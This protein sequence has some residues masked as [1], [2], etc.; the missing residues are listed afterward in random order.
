MFC[1]NCG[2]ENTGA[3]CSHCG[4]KLERFAVMAAEPAITV[5]PAQPAHQMQP[6]PSI[7]APIN[8][9]AAPMPPVR[10]AVPSR[11]PGNGMPIPPQPQQKK[12]HEVVHRIGGSAAFLTAV[13]AV[14]L[15][16]I[17]FFGQVLQ[18]S[19]NFEFDEFRLFMF[20]SWGP[21]L[22]FFFLFGVLI[23][24]GLWITFGTTVKHSG[25]QMTTAGLTMIKVVSVFLLIIFCLLSTT[26]IIV[27]AVAGV[28][29]GEL[30][31][32]LHK[33]FGGALVNMEEAG[34]LL[35]VFAFS[36]VVCGIVLGILYFAGIIKTLN[37]VRESVQTG[38]I[39]DRVSAYV[40][41][42]NFLAA[43]LMLY[44]AV[45]AIQAD[46]I[47]DAFQTVT[48][49]VGLITFG[50]CIF[51]YRDAMRRARVSDEPG[52]M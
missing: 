23:L 44:G 14:T 34:I 17:L 3:F 35:Y 29:L 43:T 5:P 13:I 27:L 24:V 40:A 26:M 19:D 45:R 36:L 18:F 25:G 42:I 49:C 22:G 8:P 52:P 48:Q 2:T 46:Q 9:S 15:S 10:C 47:L 32:A 7:P 1:P 50:V 37:A 28:F 41:V 33:V 16:M 39:N 51:Q 31:E 20:S 30:G 21:F 38:C 11:Q 4:S 6:P 12:G